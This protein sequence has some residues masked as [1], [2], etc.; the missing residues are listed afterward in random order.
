MDELRFYIDSLNKKEKYGLNEAQDPLTFF[1]DLCCLM[2]DEFQN[3]FKFERFSG[4]KSNF[5]LYIPY[6]DLYTEKIR[7]SFKKNSFLIIYF[8]KNN[9]YNLEPF[10]NEIVIIKKNK[11][12]LK[13]II[14]FITEI[15][16]YV[17][18]KRDFESGWLKISDS[19][20]ILYPNLLPIELKNSYLFFLEKLELAD[21][22][23]N[24]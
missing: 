15:K 3:Y 6:M 4:I 9:S 17:C 10:L 18:W 13:S 8:P 20:S 7:F 21:E 2:G 14:Q 1:D 19:D 16:H 12:R 24:V 23:K 5:A 22:K 11:F